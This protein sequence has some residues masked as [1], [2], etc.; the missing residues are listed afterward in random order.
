MPSLKFRNQVFEVGEI[1]LNIRTLLDRQQY[2]DDEGRAEKLGIY[3]STWSLFGVVWPS[4]EML[5]RLMYDHEIGSKRILEVGCGVALASLLLKKRDADITAVDYHPEAEALIRFNSDL[6]N[7]DELP[8]VRAS[9]A[10]TKT[11]IGNFDLVIGSDLLYDR[12]H[13]EM[14]AGFIDLHGKKDCDV[15]I[16]DPGRRHHSAFTKNMIGRGFT[17]SFS[18]IEP[19]DY[20]DAGF[21]GKILKYNR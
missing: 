2:S 5:A 14:L 19:E 3:S 1:E 12:S 8:Y 21:K 6:N 13:V 20:L 18:S 4:G 11:D 17:Y 16:V 9:W 10:D 7:L 15:M